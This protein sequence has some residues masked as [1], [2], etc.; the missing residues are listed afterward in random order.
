ML[1]G[2]NAKIRMMCKPYVN[3]NMI[4]NDP[5]L[6]AIIISVVVKSNLEEN[7]KEKK[8]TSNSSRRVPYGLGEP[9]IGT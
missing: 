4:V 9:L 7:K 1:I 6:I 8:V 5:E 2:V 3:S